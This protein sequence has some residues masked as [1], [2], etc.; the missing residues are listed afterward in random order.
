VQTG[1]VRAFG[2]GLRVD[3][4]GFE[5]RKLVAR[6][7]DTALAEEEVVLLEGAAD[8]ADEEDGSPDFV[9]PSCTIAA[10]GHSPPS[11]VRAFRSV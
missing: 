11:K 5:E 10:L 7:A 4:G 9:Y 2:G 1:G 3:L 6:D 8:L